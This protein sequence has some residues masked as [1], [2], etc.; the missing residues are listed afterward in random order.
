M[1]ASSLPVLI[2]P[3]V[4]RYLE[5]LERTRWPGR[6]SVFVYERRGPVSPD[7]FSF[8]LGATRGGSPPSVPV[9]AHV[10]SNSR[11]NAA[12]TSFSRASSIASADIGQPLDRWE[13]Q[14]SFPDQREFAF[15]RTINA[16]EPL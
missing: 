11:D 9:A 15:W 10:I 14:S 7:H 6:F 16:D 12:S 3:L 5:D 1:R 4:T 8:S 13:G 2:A